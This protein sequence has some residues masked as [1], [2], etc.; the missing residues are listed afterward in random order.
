MDVIS[1]TDCAL[2]C[3]ST[4]AWPIPRARGG[5]MG[6]CTCVSVST[7]WKGS[8]SAQRGERHLHIT[9]GLK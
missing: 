1:Y 9:L 3:V 8:T 7:E 2:Q 6:V 4:R 5:P